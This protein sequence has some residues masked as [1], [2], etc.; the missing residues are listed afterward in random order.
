MYSLL[1]R[2]WGHP[3]TYPPVVCLQHNFKRAT[4]HFMFQKVYWTHLYI[5]N[6]FMP[7]GLPF[8]SLSIR[9]INRQC[10]CG[11][12]LLWLY[13]DMNIH[14]MYLRHSGIYTWLMYFLPFCKTIGSNLYSY[15]Q[16]LSFFLLGVRSCAWWGFG[17]SRA[18]YAYNYY[19]CKHFN[20][21]DDNLVLT[22]YFMLQLMIILWMYDFMFVSK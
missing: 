13:S 7:T 3:S 16:T 18:V 22:Y 9:T 10:C 15:F 14:W 5:F 21:D 11:D 20:N 4:S 2:I 8:W 6:H 12:Q 19:V 1:L 17:G